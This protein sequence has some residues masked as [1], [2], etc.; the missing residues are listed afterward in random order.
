MGERPYIEVVVK[1]LNLI[2]GDHTASEEYWQG[3]LK[4]L[5]EEQFLSTL[6]LE[7][8]AMTSLKHYIRE[9]PCYNYYMVDV[10]TGRHQPDT[11]RSNGLCLLFSEVV[12]LLGLTFNKS[13]KQFATNADLFSYEQPFDVMDVVTI[14][15]KIKTIHVLAHSQGVVL[16]M[17]ANAAEKSRGSEFARSLYEAS[18][19]YFRMSLKAMPRDHRTWR[20][21]AD[22]FQQL[23]FYNLAELFYIFSLKVLPTESVTLYKLAHFYVDC[24]NKPKEAEQKFKESLAAEPTVVATVGLVTLISRA[25]RLQEAQSLL[26]DAR[27][28]W[29]DSWALEWHTARTLVQLSNIQASVP[30]IERALQLGA[31]SS[32]IVPDYNALLDRVGDPLGE[33]SLRLPVPEQDHLSSMDLTT[34]FRFMKK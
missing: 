34:T 20:N 11:I 19:D 13:Y 12:D 27:I 9:F 25:G 22:V 23:K 2:F 24:R 28:T 7:E 8:Q 17:R 32:L 30:H 14:N 26:N 15:E 33:V 3:T 18:L 29:P 6:T 10:K 16:R 4:P 31:P 1:S 5:L 21:T